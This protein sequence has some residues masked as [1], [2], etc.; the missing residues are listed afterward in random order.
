MKDEQALRRLIAAT[1]FSTEST[2]MLPS[3]Y[4]QLVAQQYITGS[5][6]IQQAI[7]LLEDYNCSHVAF[8]FLA[9]PNHPMS[10]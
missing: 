5:L 10:A 1:L 2:T 7:A 4:E 6:S 3:P 8:S 9:L